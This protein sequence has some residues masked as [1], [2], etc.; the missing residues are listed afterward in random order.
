MVTQKSFA[1]LIRSPSDN[2]RVP[3]LYVDEQYMKQSNCDADVPGVPTGTTFSGGLAQT[4]SLGSQVQCATETEDFRAVPFTVTSQTTRDSFEPIGDRWGVAAPGTNLSGDWVVFADKEF[5]HDYDEYLLGLGQPFLVR[6]VALSIIGRT[7]E[8]CLQEQGG[9]KLSI[10]GT[11]VRGVWDRTLIAS[12]SEPGLPEFTPTKV[13][14]LTADAEEVEAEAWWEQ[15]GTV[16]VSW[17]RGVKKYG[18][19]SF[20]SRRYLE[21]SGRTYVCQSAFYPN[22]ASK[23]VLRLT[24]RF[25]RCASSNL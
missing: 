10:Q 7:T 20:E 25:Q 16:H 5:R 2:T 1:S 3:A 11:N 21:D 6:R 24:W 22:D 12:G 14:V 4:R 19:G 18:G 9:K 17:L 8:K 13:P 15:E 23:Q